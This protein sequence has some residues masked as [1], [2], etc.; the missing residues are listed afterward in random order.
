M[1]AFLDRERERHPCSETVDRV[2]SLD[3]VA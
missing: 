2:V 3:R 1:D